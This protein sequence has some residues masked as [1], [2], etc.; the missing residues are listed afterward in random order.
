LLVLD[1]FERTNHLHVVGELLWVPLT[2]WSRV[3][4]PVSGIRSHFY[5]AV[6]IDAE[7]RTLL[8]ARASS[9]PREFQLSSAPEAYAAN[10]PLVAMVVGDLDGDGLQETVGLGEKSLWVWRQVS[11]GS[12]ELVRHFSFEGYPRA[13]RPSRELLGYMQ[14]VDL[15]QDGREEVAFW[16]SELA[17]GH[18]VKWSEEGLEPVRVTQG[19]RACGR[20][21]RPRTPLR[22]CGVPLGRT[23]D[24]ADSEPE[25]WLGH[26][27]L[28][29]HDFQP[30]I[31]RWRMGLSG[32]S[33]AVSGLYSAWTRFEL[34]EVTPGTS[35]NYFATVDAEGALRVR[36]EQGSW[37]LPKSGLAVVFADLNDDGVAELI[38]TAASW[39]GERDRLYVHSLSQTG[40]APILWEHPVP[41]V[42]ALAVGDANND[43]QLEI[44][45]LADDRF[46]LIREERNERHDG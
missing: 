15:D 5:A 21:Q 39:P 23:G 45:V 4:R 35:T 14:L 19:G 17:S 16:N 6:R 37:L 9:T 2:F 29:R 40:S 27:Q 24:G 20:S 26:V 42:H 30:R 36:S 34:H 33:Q 3:R 43:G 22:L 31:S 13:E 38:R 32:Q 44:V 12:P 8:D 41:A 1:V 28:G 11:T 7:L 46:H 10:G 25:L 18:L